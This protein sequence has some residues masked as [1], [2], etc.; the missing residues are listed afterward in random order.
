MA[1][2]EAA[3]IAAASVLLFAGCSK[4]ESDTI[5]I[6]GIFPLSGSVAVYGV[7]CRQAIDLAIEEINAAG[8]INGYQVEWIFEDDEHDAE[9]ALNAYNTCN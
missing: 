7:T 9:K 1:Q 8:G 2:G 3:G 6:G 4:Q 5:K